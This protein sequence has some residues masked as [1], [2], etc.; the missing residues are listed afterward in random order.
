MP[1]L[2]RRTLTYRP[3]TM[4]EDGDDWVDILRFKMHDNSRDPI[5]T[6]RTWLLDSLA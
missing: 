3:Q 4:K 5:P 2:S 1:L 6:E